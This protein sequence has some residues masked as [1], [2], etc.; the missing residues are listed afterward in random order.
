VSA[1]DIVEAVAAQANVAPS[2]IEAAIP[3]EES[4]RPEACS[5]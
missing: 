2:V 4:G 3:D 5:G 1:A